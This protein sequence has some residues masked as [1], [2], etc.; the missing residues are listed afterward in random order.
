MTSDKHCLQVLDEILA[1]GEEK[2]GL[3]NVVCFEFSKLFA[4]SESCFLQSKTFEHFL[5][6]AVLF[7]PVHSRGK[8]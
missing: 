6:T 3:I 4:Q 5:T 1:I 2:E 8:R 7:G